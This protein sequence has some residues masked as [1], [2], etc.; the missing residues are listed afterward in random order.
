MSQKIKKIPSPAER[1]ILDFKED[2]RLSAIP[3]DLPNL[4][5][6][7]KLAIAGRLRFE[8]EGSTTEI[9]FIPAD[10]TTI[11]CYSVIGSST[12]NTA[13]SFTV[14]NDGQTRFVVNLA[15]RADGGSV[16]QVN[17]MDS[18]VG[19]GI[20]EYRVNKSAGG[21]NVSLLF[22]VENTSRIRETEI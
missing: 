1:I 3:V 15:S 4:A 20:K 7:R 19:N 5:L 21:N 16:I 2:S 13:Q 11:F 18:L 9:V 22:W 6:L 17:F 14:V 12:V 8:Q 10:G